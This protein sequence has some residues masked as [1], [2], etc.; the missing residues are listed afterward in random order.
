M[1]E[2][3]TRKFNINNFE[4]IQLEGEGNHQDA[5]IAQLLATQNILIKVQQHLN[6]IYHTRHQHNNSSEYDIVTWNQITFELNLVQQELKSR[7]I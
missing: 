2:L 7:G 3:V 4:T 1:Q 5:Y 6:R